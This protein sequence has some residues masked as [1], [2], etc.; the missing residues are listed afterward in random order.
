MFSSLSN[1]FRH[2][3]R[4][5]I[6]CTLGMG[7]GLTAFWEMLRRFG[8]PI[9]HLEYLLIGFN[10]DI[11]Q[12][13]MMFN[14]YIRSCSETLETLFISNTLRCDNPSTIPDTLGPLPLLVDLRIIMEGVHV[15][16]D[17]LLDNCPALRTLR[18][19]VKT[20]TMDKND[21]SDD[22]THGLRSLELTKTTAGTNVFSYLSHRCTQLNSMRLASMK[23]IGPVSE[24]TGALYFDMSNTNFDSLYLTSVFFYATNGGTED[25]YSSVNLLNFG[26]S[27]PDMNPE[28]ASETVF[29]LE[30]V[31]HQMPLDDP[32]WLHVYCNVVSFLQMDNRR[33]LDQ[34]ESD[35][36]QEYFEAYETNVESYY[37]EHIQ[38][39]LWGL[40]PKDNWEDDL[41]RGYVRFYF[42]YVGKYV[43]KTYDGREDILWNKLYVTLS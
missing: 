16:I 24:D 31:D 29:N 21:I 30:G 39:T 19:T 1:P 15:A 13:I 18:L 23:V 6:N 28:G 43:I 2:L 5:I 10:S 14:E 4:I 8:V 25:D 17:A 11:N 3:T 22:A 12:L 42:N 7:W 38:R 40:V 20:I 37:P 9:K 34:E 35:Y 32:L 27:D 26:T 41:H 36:T 33:I